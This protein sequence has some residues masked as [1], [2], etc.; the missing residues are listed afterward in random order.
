MPRG[1]A[2]SLYSLLVRVERQNR[3]YL[4][5]LLPFV[6]WIPPE[7]ALRCWQVSETFNLFYI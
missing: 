6:A 7:E 5:R 1:D 3:Q 4:R 2:V